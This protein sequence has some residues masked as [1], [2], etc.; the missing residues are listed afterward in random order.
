MPTPTHRAVRLLAEAQRLRDE[1]EPGRALRA[2]RDAARLF[3][4]H[5]GPA[6]PDAANALLEM[7]G[8]LLHLGRHDE[9]H[10]HLEEVLRI[11]GRGPGGGARALLRYEAFMLAGALA[12]LQA[13]YR[14]A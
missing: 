11:A 14:R 3:L 9:A 10:R 8:A 7:S 13:D 4:K 2:S 5:D 6:S 1:N 12:V